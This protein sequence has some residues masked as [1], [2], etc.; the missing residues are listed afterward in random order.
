M[1]SVRKVE[2]YSCFCACEL[3]SKKRMGRKRERKGKEKVAESSRINRG[4]WQRPGV[5]AGDAVAAG[6]RRVSRVG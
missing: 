3:Q 6:H 5:I 4:E 1:P 2:F